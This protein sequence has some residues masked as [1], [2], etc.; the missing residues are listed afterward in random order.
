MAAAIDI[1]TLQGTLG[2][3]VWFHLD[4]SNDV[5]YLRNKAMRNH[6]VFGEETLEGFTLLHTDSGEVAGMTVVNYWNR[7]GSGELS[8][9]TIQ[10]V[11]E[12]VS[13]WMASHFAAA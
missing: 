7:F 8:T 5:L 10:T 2:D 1:D 13:V 9:A 3:S 4:L 6:S 12:Q 11:K